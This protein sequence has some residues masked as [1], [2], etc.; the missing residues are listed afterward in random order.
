MNRGHV[1]TITNANC[2]VLGSEI[3]PT[4][5]GERKEWD[6]RVVSQPLL[7]NSFIKRAGARMLGLRSKLN[8]A[9]FLRDRGIVPPTSHL[10]CR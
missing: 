8:N 6:G 3:E 4:E 1:T 2:F 5:A 7:N 9:P 10:R